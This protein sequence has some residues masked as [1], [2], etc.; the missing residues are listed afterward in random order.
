MQ[1]LRQ[2]WQDTLCR[3]GKRLAEYVLIAAYSLVAILV[4]AVGITDKT[5][6]L[7]GRAVETANYGARPE[8]KPIMSKL[9]AAGADFGEGA[10]LQ[11]IAVLIVYWGRRAKREHRD[12]LAATRPAG[13]P[14]L[15]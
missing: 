13:P 3:S 6:G 7:F 11:V 15:L 14:F 5:G 9:G 4:L 12:A 1:R 2:L 10:S 8:L